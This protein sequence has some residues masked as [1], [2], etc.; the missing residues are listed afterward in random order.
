MKK[1]ELMD[2]L[3]QEYKTHEQEFNQLFA[4]LLKQESSPKKSTAKK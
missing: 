1:E 4:D 2:L 3:D